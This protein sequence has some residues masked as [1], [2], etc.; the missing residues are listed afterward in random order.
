MRAPS[1]ASTSLPRICVPRKAQLGGGRDAHT[2]RPQR[3]VRWPADVFRCG[4]RTVSTR[5]GQLARR[6]LTE[7]RDLG[8]GFRITGYR[9]SLNLTSR[10]PGV[11]GGGCFRRKRP[12]Q[13]AAQP[14]AGVGAGGQRG[15][16]LVAVPAPGQ[17]LLLAAAGELGAVAVEQPPRRPQMPDVPIAGVL[18]PQLH[19]PPGLDEHQPPPTP[20]R[21]HTAAAARGTR[22]TR[23]PRTRPA[24]DTTR[25]AP[26]R[27]CRPRR[28]GPAG[29][30][31]RQ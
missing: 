13:G 14:V 1:A 2:R 24:P 25:S 26:H 30:G 11:R 17:L 19:R 29:V 3:T 20:A 9:P 15:G 8:Q 12:G 18:H 6:Q 5:L 31:R 22:R 7:R 23:T 28:P 16:L 4:A 27:G 21:V 10:A